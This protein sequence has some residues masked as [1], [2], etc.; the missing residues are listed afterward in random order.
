MNA[1]PVIIR[2]ARLDDIPS[3]YACLDAVA[4]EARY[5][6]FFEAPAFAQSQAYWTEMIERGCPF[7]AVLD[8]TRAVGWSDVTPVPRPAYAHCGTLG[9]GLH[10]DYR[11]RGIGR[12][13][14]EATVAAAWRYG[15]ERIELTVFIS[16][17]R[18]RLLYEKAGF[19]PEG[20]LRRHRKVNGVYEDSLF[21]ALLRDRQRGEEQ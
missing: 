12:K 10:A 17:L 11:G 5:L 1:A 20:V 2:P 8:G 3:L 16:N 15:L 4:R 18:A 19:L 14:L 13:L 9:I 6:A 7:Q 21:M